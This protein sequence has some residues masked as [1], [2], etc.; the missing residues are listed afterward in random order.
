MDSRNQG[1]VA[2][3]KKSQ[4][5]ASKSHQQHQKQQQQQD[6]DNIMIRSR[7][8]ASTASAPPSDNMGA[9]LTSNSIS[10][11]GK[12]KRGAHHHHHHYH[13]RRFKI[14]FFLVALLMILAVVGMG[15]MSIYSMLYLTDSMDK[16]APNRHLRKISSSQARSYLQAVRDQF[17]ERYDNEVFAARL[18]LE[19][20]VR[21]I[22]GPESIDHTAQR[23]VAASQEGRP[24]VMA[25]SGYSITVGRGNFFNQSF[26][27]VVQG[28]LQEPFQNVFGIPLTVRNAAIGGIPSF[29]YGF[30]MEHFLGRDPDV[31]SWD[32]SMN[33][34]AKDASVL[35]AFV[36]QATEQLP[37][38]PMI[39]ML[40]TNAN[41]IKLLEDYVAAGKS[42]GGWLHDAIAVGKKDVLPGGDEKKIVT[43]A[44]P[45]PPGFQEWDEFG[46]VRAV[47][48]CFLLLTLESCFTMFG[49][50]LT[51]QPFF[52]LSSPKIV[53]DVGA[54]ISNGRSML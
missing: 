15:L 49:R 34:G 16:P 1:T 42:S 40:D 37:Q 36:R 24:F 39:I 7:A 18:L 2:R 8:A 26:P 4:A 43:S 27:F 11:D 12:T 47:C 53:L 35:E 30:C 9:N 45:V 46:A 29:P 3:T 41:R 32:Y 23:I 13:H 21:T 22:G 25:F 52:S 38:R 28:I 14:P 17:E 19:K 51:H 6:D 50:E 48:T 54:G 20:G 31:V 10:S 44:N 33:E 5:K